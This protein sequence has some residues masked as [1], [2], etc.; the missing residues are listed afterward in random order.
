M[1]HGTYWGKETHLRGATALLREDPDN[2]D[3][4]LAQFDDLQ[5]GI[6]AHGWYK[7]PKEVW[8]HVGPIG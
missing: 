5:L 2:S 8:K 6:W 7:F 3:N 4:Y 1:Y